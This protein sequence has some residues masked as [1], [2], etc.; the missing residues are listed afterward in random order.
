MC[1]VPASASAQLSPGTSGFSDEPR[2]LTDD[3]SL[4]AIR[5]LGNCLA[6][7]K[8]ALA[9]TF[10]STTPGTPAEVAAS[11]A[12]IGKNTA[13]LSLASRARMPIW[14]LRGVVTEALYRN[15]QPAALSRVGDPLPATFSTQAVQSEPY[16]LLAD[17]SRCFAASHPDKLHYLLTQT[18]VG[19]KE[20]K[21][22]F[23]SMEETFGSCLP[24]RVK[25]GFD[26]MEIRFGLAE[27][28]YRRSATALPHIGQR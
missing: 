21:A 9:R 6:R 28:A 13:C 3:D 5:D 17:F 19:T 27:A 22:A 4:R 24:N 26:P 14:L 10:V 15:H 1:L 23:T 7:T 18:R 12:L 11:R 16:A 20:E 8:V 2:T 25:L